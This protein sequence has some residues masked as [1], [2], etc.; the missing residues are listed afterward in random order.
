MSV[1]TARRW[2]KDR[3]REAVGEG[4]GPLKIMYRVDGTSDLAEESLDH[5]E[6]YRGSS[7][8]R[9][10]NGAADQP[11]FRTVVSGGGME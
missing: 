11:A 4:S 8:A 10:G 1:T 2:V 9:I 5:W 7:P 6:G 3:I